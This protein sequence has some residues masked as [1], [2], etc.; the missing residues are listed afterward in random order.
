MKRAWVVLISGASSGI[1]RAAA[2]LLAKSGRRAFAGVRRPQA[3]DFA[4][5]IIRVPIR[6][7]RP[8]RDDHS[9]AAGR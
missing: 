2:G 3:A 6:R 5:G 8:S 9:V 4:K 7:L 1:G